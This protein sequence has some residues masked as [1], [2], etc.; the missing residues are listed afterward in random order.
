MLNKEILLLSLVILCTPAIAADR[1]SKVDS[2]PQANWNIKKSIQYGSRKTNQLPKGVIILHKNRS[3]SKTVVSKANLNPRIVIQVLNHSAILNPQG[4]KYPT[5][6][7]L[8]NLTL[9]NAKEIFGTAWPKGNGYTFHLWTTV[10]PEKDIYH[11]DTEF[12]SGYLSSYKIRGI[13]I[14][15]S[16][17]IKVQ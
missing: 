5:S 11:L 1:N 7:S 10:G 14:W 3:K 15:N 17:W 13:N 9:E 16:N 8:K 4:K 6:A 12:S 2:N